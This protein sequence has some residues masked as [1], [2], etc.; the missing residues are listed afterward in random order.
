MRILSIRLTRGM[1]SKPNRQSISSPIRDALIRP[2]EALY[3]LATLER[4]EGFQHEIYRCILRGGGGNQFDM[5]H[6][7]DRERQKNGQD[8]GDR[9]VPADLVDFAKEALATLRALL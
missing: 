6:S 2:G 5:P 9:S 8:C 7:G 3:D 4:L 1:K